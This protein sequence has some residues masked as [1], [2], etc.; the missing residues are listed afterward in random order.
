MHLVHSRCT[1][2]CT[3]SKIN[4]KQ[5]PRN[6]DIPGFLASII[7][8]QKATKG[9]YRIWTC[10]PVLA[11]STD[12]ESVALPLCQLSITTVNIIA[13]VAPRCYFFFVLIALLILRTKVTIPVW[14]CNQNDK[15][16]YYCANCYWSCYYYCWSCY[17]SY[18]YS[19]CYWP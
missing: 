14:V 3:T 11:G 16:T 5:K 9:E 13:K 15:T 6:V 8:Y 12:F 4:T 1:Q 19:N 10:A 2:K 18:C 17:L 7:A